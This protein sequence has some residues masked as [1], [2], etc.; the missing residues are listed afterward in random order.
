VTAAEHVA[1]GSSH[2]SLEASYYRNALFIG[3]PV[4]IWRATR[5]ETQQFYPENKRRYEEWLL[6]DPFFTC[7]YSNCV[8]WFSLTA[9]CGEVVGEVY[10][11]EVVRPDGKRAFATRTTQTIV[12]LR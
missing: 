1:T 6:T 4:N 10:S 12:A 9:M 8:L 7:S 2:A 11:S 3:C 5:I